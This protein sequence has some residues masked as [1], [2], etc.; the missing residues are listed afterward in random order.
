LVSAATV[1]PA[2]MSRTNGSVRTPFAS[3]ATRFEA[4]EENAT[5]RP[6][7]LID[8]AVAPPSTGAGE[9]T[10]AGRE[11]RTASR[12]RRAADRRLAAAASAGTWFGTPG[13]QAS[14]DGRKKCP[15]ST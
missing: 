13:G 8:G 2:S 12:G 6:S 5:Y 15:N 7:P 10:R 1:L 4:S 11:P 14:D 9:K 3:P